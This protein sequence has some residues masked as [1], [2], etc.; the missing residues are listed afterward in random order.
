MNWVY[1][2][3]NTICQQRS[4]HSSGSLQTRLTVELAALAIL[5]LGS[6]ALWSSYKLQQMVMDAPR[7]GVEYTAGWLTREVE[8]SRPELPLKVTLQETIQTGTGAG[9]VMW[10]RAPDR[11]LLAY[12]PGLSATL[13]ETA[14]A[15]PIAQMPRS[16]QL[17]RMQER[18][19]MV[20]TGPLTVRGRWVGTIYIAQDVTG[21]QQQLKDAVRA[22]LGVSGLVILLVVGATALCIRRSLHPLQTMSQQIG[23]LVATDFKETQLHL[24]P[25]PQEVQALA[26]T[27]SQLLSRLSDT[28]AAQRQFVQNISHEL[29]TPLTV[30]S[31]Y[32]QSV[33]RRSANLPEHQR[34]A[35][36][37]AS[38]ETDHTIR[39]LQ[40]LLDLAR[41]DSECLHYHLEPV[42]LTDL[43]AEVAGMTETFSD[44]PI[45][46]LASTPVIALV[47][48][49]RLKQ[50][51]IHLIDNAV[52]YSEP[53]Q[54]IVLILKVE[55]ERT[56]IQVCDRGVGIPLQHQSRIFERFY[57]VDAARARSTGGHGL[58]L[59]L[60]K[61]F[62][63]GMGGRITVH[64]KPGVG[65]QFEIT[66]PIPFSKLSANY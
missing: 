54:P 24:N 42:E 5:G 55:T 61:T 31:G 13:M 21:Q 65:S 26:Q 22:V 52:N 43:V 18:D 63:E 44:R 39:L 30:V 41:A 25:A 62:I 8:R 17:Y 3:W 60:V 49:D 35:L 16:P 66:L 15:L 2:F 37:T 20:Y 38:A 27:F 51:L 58:G 14:T 32:L 47:D 19:W 23:D 48:R 12:S 1:H 7:Q 53:D 64:S 45:Q 9:V 57:R 56:L 28:S 59:A 4:R 29:R 11:Q 46:V 40:D 6:V 10:A 50:A 33:L 34:E 36:A